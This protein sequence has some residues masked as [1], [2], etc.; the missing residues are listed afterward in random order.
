MKIVSWNV[1]G[2]RS[3]HSKG[4]LEW[5]KKENADIV[6]IQEIK[7]DKESI[8]EGFFNIKSH[9]CISLSA[10]KKGY[11]GVLT[12][13]KKEPIKTTFGLKNFKNEGRTLIHEFESF[14]LI[15][16]YFPNGGREHDRIPYK[17]KYC[18]AIERK[19]NQL[20]KE[21]GKDVIMTGD[22]NVAHHPV[23]L[24]NDKSNKNT[25]G[26]LPIERQWLDK[27]HKKGF[28]DFFRDKYPDNEDAYSWWSYR[29]DCRGRNIGWRIDYFWGHMNLN[30]A[31]TDCYYQP[32]TLG[33]DHCPIILKINER[34]I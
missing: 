7:A 20:K 1:N 25:T 12:L 18:A 28:R 34:K 11:S 5:F 13:T 31:I 9:H 10:E 27:I 8:P 30:E 33:S 16:C 29:N 19:V 32:E 24:K 26:F 17:M 6:C 15:N 2:I 4:F 14:F 3:I 21:T 22:F 23:D